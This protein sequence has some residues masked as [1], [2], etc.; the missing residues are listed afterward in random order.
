MWDKFE[1]RRSR[2]ASE[3]QVRTRLTDDANEKGN[4]WT[5]KVDWFGK[6][7]LLWRREYC[8]KSS[9]KLINKSMSSINLGVNISGHILYVPRARELVLITEKIKINCLQFPPL[10]TGTFKYLTRWLQLRV[11]FREKFIPSE[12]RWLLRAKQRAASFRWVE[13]K[14]R[15]STAV[16]LTEK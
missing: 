16:E 13:N 4:L 2:F 3:L 7:L 15:K 12:P 8:N 1:L 14:R 10:L 9:T 6:E 5:Q 11:N